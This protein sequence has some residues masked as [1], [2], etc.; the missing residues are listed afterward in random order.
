MVYTPMCLRIY[1]EGGFKC[2]AKVMTCSPEAPKKIRMG[3][4]GCNYYTPVG[5]HE[6]ARDHV[7]IQE[8]VFSLQT[9]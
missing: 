6:L 8:A 7:I 4:L 1:L 3:V 2:D 5:E 9:S